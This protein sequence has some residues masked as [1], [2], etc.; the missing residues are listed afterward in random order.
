[1]G[2]TWTAPR[3]T[4]AS[5]TARRGWPQLWAASSS[6]P[7]SST[8]WGTSW[9]SSPCIGTR[10]SG[11]Q[12]SSERRAC[13]R[14]CFGRARGWKVKRRLKTKTLVVRLKKKKEKS[15]NS[16]AEVDTVYESTQR[17]FF[18]FFFFFIRCF[19]S[20]LFLMENIPVFFP[21]FLPG[22]PS[23]F[24]EIR[25]VNEAVFLLLASCSSLFKKTFIFPWCLPLKSPSKNT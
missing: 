3:Q 16:L 17:L 13:V 21:S 10:S 20:R 24:S 23:W 19:I 14:A 12:V 2:L 18:F 22:C 8:S 7:S 25:A 9:S 11:T 6:S 5:W 4:P 15:G 1:M